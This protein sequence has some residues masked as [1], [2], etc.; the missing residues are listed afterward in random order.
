MLVAAILL[1]VSWQGL[2]WSGR[3]ET[4]PKAAVA[5][6]SIAVASD[7]STADVTLRVTAGAE[8]LG[9][10]SVFWIVSLPQTQNGWEAPRYSAPRKMLDGLK[11]G[12]SVDLTWQGVHLPLPTGRYDVT[13]WVHEVLAPDHDEHLAGGA[14]GA[15]SITRPLASATDLDEGWL[16]PP[17]GPLVLRSLAVI[18]DVPETQTVSVKTTVAN[19][20]D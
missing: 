15:F 10:L 11:S 3:L 13:G 4:V 5:A 7:G 2:A 16:S 1:A 17:G 9:P 14:I 12:N 8:D 19:M 18:D 20:G 6:H